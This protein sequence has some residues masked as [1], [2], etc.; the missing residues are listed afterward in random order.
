MKSKNGLLFAT[1]NGTPYLYNGLQQRWLTP[2]LRAMQIDEKGMGFHAFRRFRKTWLRGERC[3]EDINNFWMGHQPET[4]S[5]P[6]SRMEFE[7]VRR[8]T[9]AE[10]IGV[11]FTVPTAENSKCSKLLQVLQVLQKLQDF[12][13]IGCRIGVATLVESTS[14]QEC[15][16]SA[17]GQSVCLLSTI[18]GS[19][20][21]VLFS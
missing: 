2:R 11:G 10:N 8:L 19:N 12:E 4:M 5:E 16:R 17:A 15:G 18:V 6:Y 13:P 9:E 20:S 1:R 21:S 7:L 3:Q 14:S